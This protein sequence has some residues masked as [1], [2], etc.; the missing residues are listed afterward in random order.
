MAQLRSFFK[1]PVLAVTATCTSKVR[2]DILSV[3]QLNPED[4][5]IVSK[6]PNRENV[7]SIL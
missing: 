2:D 5:D 3:L 6:S 7:M 4:T 1:V